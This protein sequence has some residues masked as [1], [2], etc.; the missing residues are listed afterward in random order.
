MTRPIH[1]TPPKRTKHR[2]QIQFTKVIK[3]GAKGGHTKEA[4]PSGD[5]DFAAAAAEAGKAAEQKK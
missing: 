4:S 1:Q 5:Y 2:P 3:E